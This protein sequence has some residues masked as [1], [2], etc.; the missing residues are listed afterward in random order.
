MVSLVVP[1]L[2]E[3]A[4]VSPV[5]ITRLLLESLISATSAFAVRP[6]N[7]ALNVAAAASVNFRTSCVL[8]D[9]SVSL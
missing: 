4:S 3:L 6:V 2:T 1:V 9:E 7:V 5:S 8:V